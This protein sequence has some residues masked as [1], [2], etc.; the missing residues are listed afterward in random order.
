MD[1]YSH[2][3]S[4]DDITLPITNP[5]QHSSA[6]LHMFRRDNFNTMTDGRTG[7]VVGTTNHA[8]EQLVSQ[9]EDTEELDTLSRP[10][11]TQEQIAIL[12]DEFKGKPKPGTDF[13]KQLAAQIGLS[14]QR[15]N[16]SPS[17]ILS[18]KC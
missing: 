10:R 4:Q 18:D 7:R 1:H 12:E 16:V 2:I 5:S 3:F 13:K 17:S 11:L 8:P 6:P 14:L 9:L 15:V